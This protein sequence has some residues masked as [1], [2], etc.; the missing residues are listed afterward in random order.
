MKYKQW[1][2]S[3]N[4]Y[5]TRVVMNGSTG[6]LVIGR[7]SAATELRRILGRGV[8]HMKVISKRYVWLFREP[9]AVWRKNKRDTAT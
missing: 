5:P 8:S 1:T 9:L 7:V 2:F 6:D 3:K 4:Q